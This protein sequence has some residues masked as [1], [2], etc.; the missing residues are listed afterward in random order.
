MTVPVAYTPALTPH[1]TLH[2]ERFGDERDRPA[3][4]ARDLGKLFGIYLGR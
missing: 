2:L 4:D 3:W 1:G